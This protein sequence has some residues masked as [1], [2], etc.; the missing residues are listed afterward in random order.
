MK[1]IIEKNITDLKIGIELAEIAHNS[2]VENYSMGRIETLSTLDSSYLSDIDI[3]RGYA[4]DLVLFVDIS[5]I[6]GDIDNKDYFRSRLI[7]LCNK[8]PDVR[9]EEGV[10]ELI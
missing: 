4:I 9:N 1:D 6:I 2:F 3:A 10:S 8:Y 7:D 5:N